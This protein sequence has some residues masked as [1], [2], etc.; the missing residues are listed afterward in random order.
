MAQGRLKFPR[1]RF[2]PLAGAA[3]LDGCASPPQPKEPPGT[4]AVFVAKAS[5]YSREL[6]AIVETGIKA[7]GLSVRGKSILLKPN[8]VEFDSATTINT[9]VAL[10]AAAVETFHKMGAA[11]VRVGEGPGHRRDTLFLASEADYRK[12]LDRFDHLFVDLNRDDIA[13]VPDFAG[14]PEFF[15]PKSALAADLIVSMPKMKTH[16]WT[17]ATLSMKNFFGLVPGAVYGWPK[18][19]LHQLGIANSIVALHRVFRNT[20]AIVDGIVGMEGNGPI[21][22]SPKNAGVIVMGGDL[23][24]VDATC[25]RIMGIDP[26]KLE[27]LQLARE[28]GHIDSSRI[29]QRGETI[30]SVRTPFRLIEAFRNVRLA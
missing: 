5:S 14:Q 28:L 29:E 3:L 21:Q 20:F 30:A 24:A 18:N 17:G 12:G 27:Y 13:P 1:R 15:F 16:H 8:L 25:C 6:A 2:L 11:Q 4:S 9:N 7:C 26:S 19:V 23:P 22:G 10:L